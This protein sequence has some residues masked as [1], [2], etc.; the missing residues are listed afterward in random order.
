MRWHNTFPPWFTTGNGTR[1]GGVLSHALSA[2]YIRDLLHSLVSTKVGCNVGGVFYNVL[3]Y[4]DDL[5]LLAPS[6]YALQQLLDTLS[7]HIGDSDMVCNVKKTVCM[8]YAPS[9]KAIL[10]QRHFHC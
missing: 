2:R 5:I 9:N 6:W 3:A 4:A 1:Q 7:L 10:S 8:V